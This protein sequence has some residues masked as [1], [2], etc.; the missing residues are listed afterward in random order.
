MPA[1]RAFDHAWRIACFLL[2][3]AVA[4]ARGA[5]AEAPAAVRLDVTGVGWLRDRELRLALNRLLGTERMAHLDSNAIEDAAVILSS[6]LGEEGFQR[7][8]LQIDLQLSGGGRTTATFDP[9][10]EN[11]LPRG[12][13]ATSVTFRITPGVRYYIADVEFTGLTF[14]PAARARAFFRVES[15]LIASKRS[16]AF[17]PARVSRAADALVAELRQRGYAESE[18]RAES[19]ADEATGRVLVRV[20]VREGTPWIVREVMFQRE[21]NDPVP[22]PDV[23]AWIDVPWSATL[24]EDLRESI[25]RAYYRKGYP[26]AGIHVAV[27][28]REAAGAAVRP[29]GVTVTVIPGA[30]VKVGEVRIE[31]NRQ[32][33]ESVLRRRIHLQA[34]DPLDLVA[35]EQSRYRISRLGIF[36]AVDVRYEPAEGEVRDPVFKVR[37][38]PRY[39]TNLLAGYGSYEQVRG[40]VEHRQLNLF[41]LAHQARVELV[42]SMKSSS[43]DLTYTVPELFGESLD[44]T[45]RLFGLQRREIAF[46]RQEFGVNLSLKRAVRAIGGEATAGYTFQALRNRRNALATRTTD[47]RQFNVA[48]VNFG[49][50]GDRRDNPLRPHRGYHWSAQVESADPRLGGQSTYQRYELAGAYHTGWGGGRWLHLALSH[51]AITTLGSDGST[52]PVNKRF[53]PGGDNT[54]RGYQRGEA[55]PRGPDG[56]F[57]GAKSYLLA[58]VEVEQ[59]LSQTWSAVVFFDTLGTAQTLAGYPF[60]ERLYSAGL[61]VRYQTLIGP[62]RLEYGRNLTPRPADPPGTWHLSIGFPF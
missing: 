7:P 23:K 1:S 34:G 30:A 18:V 54:I 47:D 4:A 19:Q 51:G 45:A 50:S 6:T 14:M 44:G 56:S 42:Q 9:T 8:R 33:R 36:E 20:N 13:L 21:E 61:G 25:R 38:S 32:T 55:A 46:L 26:D 12:L 29:A 16:N 2:L 17:S 53:Y 27:E 15:T 40:G 24:Q 49:L 10:F 3:A 5:A 62:I 41:G 11:P 48:S 22:L 35:L 52:L 31:G 57:V 28:P 39:E 43:G 59:A 60:D 37:E 58:N